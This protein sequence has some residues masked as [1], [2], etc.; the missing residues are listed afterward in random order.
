MARRRG[1][2]IM[3]TL[4]LPVSFGEAADKI[5]IL[6]IKRE[7]IGDPVKR[8]GVE[9]ELGMA[10]ASFTEQMRARPG[11]AQ[12]FAELKAINIRLWEIEDA[13][14]AC[15]RRQDFGPQFVRLARSVYLTNDERFRVKREIDALFDSPIREEKS[16][17]RSGP[18]EE[19]G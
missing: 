8:A 10:L 11:F 14:R 3:T 13:V 1:T 4:V 12:L 16:Y 18:G 17:A 2:A 15:E 5:S 9:L 19:P 7:R 6:E